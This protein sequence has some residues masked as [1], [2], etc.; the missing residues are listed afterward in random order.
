VQPKWWAVFF[1]VVLLGTFLIWF[2]APFYGW[3]LPDAVSTF[4]PEVDVLFYVILG[5]TAFFFVLTEMVLVY[6]MWSFAHDPS[7]RSVYTHGSHVLEMVWTAIPAAL[8]LFIAFVQINVWSRIKYNAQMPSPN[9]TITVTARQ[10][11]WRM[12]YPAKY[13]RFGFKDETGKPDAMRAGRSW[14]E[15]PEIDDIHLPN[16][17]H[18]WKG[19][20]VK[21][22][23]RTTDVL[24]SFTLPQ[25]RLK[26]DTL[27][28]KTIPMWFN[29]TK[30][31]TVWDGRTK[32]LREPTAAADRW[33]ISCQELCG[34]RHYAMRG[35]LYVHET[36]ASFE[37]W[38][39]HQK[40]LQNAV[41]PEST[42]AK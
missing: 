8:L 25:L 42:A 31:N 28:G 38:L 21:I 10:W 24:H 37:Q 33:E 12:R 36:Q 32:T 1:A 15:N 4:G 11:E 34:G 39:E 2:I 19:A 5:M 20:N 16:E 40:T 14:A 26:Q 41:K 30:S 7:R 13:D 22:F 23:L 35:R 3:W 29:A 9:L 6:A 17:I 18:C 27:P